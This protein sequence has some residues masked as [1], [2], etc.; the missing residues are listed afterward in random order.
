MDLS[1]ADLYLSGAN[2]QQARAAGARFANANLQ[3][4]DLHSADLAG[5]DFSNANLRGSVLLGA[6][7]GGAN[8]S[9]ADLSG[10]QWTT[11]T[12]NYGMPLV[13]VCAQ[14]SIGGCK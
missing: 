14:G 6:R 7:T 5:A 3:G 11:G 4:A 8:W 1:G 12:D 9:G 13:K 10:A 2:L